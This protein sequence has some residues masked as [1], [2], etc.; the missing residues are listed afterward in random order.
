[1]SMSAYPKSVRKVT[2]LGNILDI[3]S[4]QPVALVEERGC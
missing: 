3:T 2:E 1:M 4:F